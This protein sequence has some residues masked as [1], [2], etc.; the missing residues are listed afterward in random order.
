MEW[1]GGFFSSSKVTEQFINQN[2]DLHHYW[3]TLEEGPGLHDRD[4]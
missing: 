4:K 3:H 1:Q 2:E